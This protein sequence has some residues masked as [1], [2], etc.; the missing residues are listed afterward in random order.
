MEEM[1]WHSARAA[2]IWQAE[3]G[4]TD[5]IGDVPINRYDA[6]VIAKPKVAATVA[7]VPAKQQATPVQQAEQMAAAAGNLDALNAALGSYSHCELK[8]GA[9]NLVFSDGTPSARVM[10]VGEAPGREEDLH[11]RP[12]VGQAG[13]LLDKMLAAIDLDREKSVYITNILPWRPPQNRDP[14]PDEI[15]MML[16]FVRRHI[17]LANPDVVICMGNVSCQAILG[18][19]G[20]T[21]LRGQWDQAWGKPILPM[22]HPAYLLRQ[23][24][25]K[26]DAWSDLLALKSWLRGH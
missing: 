2:L 7:D 19:R 5:T 24:A 23:T 3:L 11:A 1:D 6:P 26:R 16:P 9:R 4:V 25:A 12:F 22:L 17:E 10:I 13:R 15:A 18:K 21:K 8:R 20:I 14:N